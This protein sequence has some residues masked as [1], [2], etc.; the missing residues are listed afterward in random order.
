MHELMGPSQASRSPSGTRMDMAQR[1]PP[2]ERCLEEGIWKS[3][4]ELLKLGNSSN[5]PSHGPSDLVCSGCYNK[6]DRVI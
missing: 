6:T 3:E 2:Q 4:G 5:L 1:H